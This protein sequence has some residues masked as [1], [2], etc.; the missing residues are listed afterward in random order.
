MNEEEGLRLTEA[1]AGVT[2]RLARLDIAG[3]GLDAID[4][5]LQEYAAEVAARPE[6]HN[7]WEQLAVERFFRL[8]DKYGLNRREVRRIFAFYEFLHFPGKKGMTRYR[9]TPVQAFQFASVFGFRDAEGRRVVKE[10][11]LFVPRKFS[12]TTGSA[13]F[14]LYDLLYGD[15]N[16]SVSTWTSHPTTT[17]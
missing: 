13:T 17:T 10:C 7:L 4:A 12:K 2:A 5:R 11:V 15:D 8:I 1:K 16:P 6:A 3:Y 14:A 9:L